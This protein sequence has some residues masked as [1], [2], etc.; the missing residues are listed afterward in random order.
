MP[1]MK[2][3]L[4]LD[5][6][7][8]SVKA[9]ELRQ[10][11]RGLEPVQMRVH[12]RADPETP[13]SES[14]RRFMR[15]HNFPTEHIACAIPGDRLSTRRLEF[16]F[17]D[18]KKLAQAVP[19]E[20][21][22]EIPFELEDVLVDWELISAER[23]HATVAATIAQRTEVAALL[24]TL[25]ESG[26]EPR[27]LEAEGLVLSNLASL[28]DLAGKRLLVDVGHRKT[29]LCLLIDGRP[30]VART[31]PVAG[32]AIT[33]AIARDQGL[34]F[35]DAERAKCED[36]IFQLGF[37]SASSGAVA[38]L[39]RIARE[40][41]R[42]LESQE[43]TLGGSPEQQIDQISL[44]GGSAR[45]HKLDEYLAER[46]GIATSR[47]SLAPDSDR[48]SLVAGG[49]PSLFAPALALALRCTTQAQTRM[50]FRQDEFAYRTD[51]RRFLGKD[52]RVTAALAATA[53]ALLGVRVGTSIALE[54]REARAI[55]REVT[56]IYAG[57]FPDQPEARNPLA[58]LRAKLDEEEELADF[59]GAFGGN[60][61][62]LD[63]LAELSRRVPANLDVR[64][65]EL[66][67]DR[68]AIRVKVFA[69][70]FQSADRLKDELAGE[71]P[72]TNAKVDG[73]VRKTKEGIKFNL[74]I[75][76]E[77]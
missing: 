65:E 40:I 54:N 13:E 55:E 46:I 5:L 77:G 7:S 3:V 37:D 43:P 74:S 47:L 12:P 15:T 24:E 67:I 52:M 45:L 48:A 69:K 16:P 30:V 34:S 59:L 68:R 56:K 6:G 35:P 76:M 66:N 10:T 28:F 25:R 44:F 23:S 8:H 70:R 2:S 21:E 71:A 49:D 62:A 72:F 20:V 17:R 63:V 22:G 75:S 42:M 39:D 32:L 14:L 27:I 57:L 1:M 9:V 53:V 60:R 26:C 33:E 61:S 58:S 64:F 51:L 36:G 4:G 19:F 38:A 29:N 73:E 11:F 41:V 31:V 18:R 50:N